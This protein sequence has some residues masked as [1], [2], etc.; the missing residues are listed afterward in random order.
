MPETAITVYQ[1]GIIHPIVYLRQLIKQRRLIMLFARR[2]FHVRYAQTFLGWLW[3][4]AQPLTWLAV[5]WVFF[6]YILKV[7]TD[8]VPYPVF[9]FTGVMGWYFFS[10]SAQRTGAALID[11]RELM[12]SMYY[13]RLIVLL[14]R[15]LV[16]SIDLCISLLILAVMLVYW[17]YMPGGKLVFLPFAILAN[18]MAGITIGIW[19]S[20][21]SLRY[22]DAQQILPLLLQGGIW[23]T[24]V[25]FS[26]SI[27]PKTWHWIF[28]CNPLAGVISFYRW[29]LVGSEIPAGYYFLGFTINIILLVIGYY[30]FI[31]AE[32]KI[33]DYM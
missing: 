2:E 13:P 4:V 10:V 16:S 33:I 21:L 3:A 29:I 18:A 23:I 17:N 14:S 20:L 9:L 11:S 30:L 1:P 24:P 12:N 32:R 25:F 22:R 8:P 6:G 26:E 15:L 31:Q 5:F 27:L 28:Y 7:K 19:I